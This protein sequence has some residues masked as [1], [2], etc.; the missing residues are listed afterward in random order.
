M[1]LR[2]LTY[3]ILLLISFKLFCQTN[4]INQVNLYSNDGNLTIHPR[5]NNFIDTEIL[6]AVNSGMKVTFH[7]YS[8]IYDAQNNRIEDQENQ[9]H[10]RNDIWEN[11]YMISGNKFL[12]EFKEFEKFKIFLLD[13]IQFMINL[14]HKIDVKKQIQ[15]FLT[16]S[17]QKISTSQK[18]K[19]RIWLINEDN[20]SE[21]TLSL[22]LSKLI[23]FFMSDNKNENLS[24]YKSKMFTINSVKTNEKTKK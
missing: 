23:A 3:T 5:L 12:R 10:V 20:D 16:F 2:P 15:L 18:E 17:P 11:Q 24:V 6:D 7:F 21:S 14:K 8:E 9:I 13:S 19:V 22:N 4:F 1:N